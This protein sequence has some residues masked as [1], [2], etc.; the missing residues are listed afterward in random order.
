LTTAAAGGRGAGFSAAHTNVA[1]TIM[2]IDN[3]AFMVWILLRGRE[4]SIT[5]TS[6]SGDVWNLA[7]GGSRAESP[8]EQMWPE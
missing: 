8:L 6:I 4:R 7:D 3:T 2:Q 5:E 1:A